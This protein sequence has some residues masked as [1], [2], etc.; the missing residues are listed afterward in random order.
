[1]SFKFR[2]ILSIFLLFLISTVSESTDFNYLPSYTSTDEIVHHTAYTL[3]YD[4]KYE[5]ADWIAYKLTREMLAHRTAKR[6]EDFR[7]D[8]MV[9]TGSATP[10]DY[11]KSGYDRGH[12]CPAGDMAWDATAMAETFYMS[13]MSPQTAGFNRGVW[14]RLEDKVRAWARDND[15]IYVVAGPVL[16]EG[17]PT[18]GNDK[19]AV[20]AY[21]Y[22]VILDYEEPDIKGIG[23]VLPN[24]SSNEPLS[25]YAVTIDSIEILT[26][27]DF[28]PALPDSVENK[29][30]ATTNFNEWGVTA[31]TAMKH[32]VAPPGTVSEEN[33]GYC[34]SIKS[35]VFHY[36]S[37]PYAKKIA[38]YNLITFK[39][40]EEAIESGRRPC[41]VC[42]H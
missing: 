33:L 36:C 15:E 19:V 17:L 24:Q 31:T 34:A 27:I 38:P 37:C 11:K 22:K 39:T 1:M 9:P 40:R 4:E 16:K 6:T 3:K 10:E 29:I 20:P 12:L 18:I 35:E 23:F 8:P 32:L 14:K 41:K 13:N 21:Y 42:G 30:E 25:S 26:G 28:F 5:Q 2:F 7:P